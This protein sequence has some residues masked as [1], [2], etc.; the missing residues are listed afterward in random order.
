MDSESSQL[1]T[2]VLI[3]GAG[4]AGLACAIQLARAS[5]GDKQ[6]I[7]LEKSAHPGGHLLSGAVMRIDALK[8]LLTPKEY[9]TLPLGPAVNRE[10]FHALTPARS[11]RLPF[12]PPKMRMK[13]LPLVSVS[14]LGSALATIAENLGVEIMT[15][16]TADTLVWE[17]DQVIGVRCEEDHILAPVTVLAEGPVG[18]LTRELL[19]RHPNLHGPNLASHALG[20]K[21]LVEIPARPGSAGTVAHTFG[22]PLGLDIYGGGF[23]Y[24]VDDNHV[25]LGLAI[26]LDYA[27]PTLHLHELFR[28]WKR[29]PL[30]QAHIAGGKTIG[31]GARLVPEGGWHSRIQNNAPGAIVIGDAAGLVDTMELKG[32]HLAVESGMAA[33]EAIHQSRPVRD[34][35]IPALDGLRR[36]P[37]YRA[38]FRAGLPVGMMAAGL[39]WLSGGRLPWGRIAQRDERASLKPAQST[40]P[41]TESPDNGTLDLGLDSDLFLANLRS[42]EGAE[43]IK[44]K[45]AALCRECFALYAAPCLRFCPAS[46]YAADGDKPVILVRPDNCVQ[47]RCCTL[48]CPFD[49]IAWETPRHGVGPD[50]HQM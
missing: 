3:V 35:D 15:S 36:T 5:A 30:V 2:D 8:K 50:Y 6:I 26:A 45:D 23:I 34:S 7:V 11:F 49:N 48:V 22:F 32:L 10:S 33:A 19:A 44:I 37:N 39:A 4:L 9:A 29:H 14:A 42:R 25:G 41:A 12:V 1:T 13:G 18:L 20:F 43:H 47:C 38:A 27:D 21:E 40:V 46:V 17:G 31:Y 16:Q 24:H 28:A